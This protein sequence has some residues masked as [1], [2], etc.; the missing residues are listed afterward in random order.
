M[1]ASSFVFYSFRNWKHTRPVSRNCLKLFVH[2]VCEPCTYHSWRSQTLLYEAGSRNILLLNNKHTCSYT[3][4]K[5]DCS[6]QRQYPK[7]VKLLLPTT[8]C[9][10][11]NSSR[12]MHLDWAMAC[13]TITVCRG[14]LEL[15]AVRSMFHLS[16]L[17]KAAQIWKIFT[18]YNIAFS[19]YVLSNSFQRSKIHTENQ[20]TLKMF[21]SLYAEFST[22]FHQ[23]QLAGLAASR[24]TVLAFHTAWLHQGQLS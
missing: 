20:S 5:G 3:Y 10:S 21:C 23:R 13:K 1:Y 14:L 17:A 2:V 19:E 4:I 15:T 22:S 24:T 7:P 16:Q 9:I 18:T 12:H 8:K 11:T 6:Q